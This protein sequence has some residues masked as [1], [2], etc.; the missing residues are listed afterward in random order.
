V[1]CCRFLK[2]KI[3]SCCESLSSIFI[4][5]EVHVP[6]FV[7]VVM[8]CQAS[9]MIFSLLCVC[10]SICVFRYTIFVHPLCLYFNSLS[11][12]LLPFLHCTCFIIFVCNCCLIINFWWMNRTMLFHYI[13]IF[14]IPLGNALPQQTFILSNAVAA[15]ETRYLKCCTLKTNRCTL[16]CVSSYHSCFVKIYSG[17]SPFYKIGV[18]WILPSINIDLFSDMSLFWWP[19]I[20]DSVFANRWK[21]RN[22]CNYITF[23]LPSCFTFQNTIN[24]YMLCIVE[25]FY[26]LLL[27]SSHWEHFFVLSSHL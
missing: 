14:L 25:H 7:H 23:T 21:C 10:I 13:Y 22:H 16:L 18:K 9:V 8:P 1:S 20:C 24:V 4:N 17:L 26:S 5:N 19:L 11:G 2:M 12:I 3:L 27:S 6:S 15:V